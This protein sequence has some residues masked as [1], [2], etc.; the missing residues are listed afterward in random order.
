MNLKS[1]TFLVALVMATGFIVACGDQGPQNT[2]SPADQA[3]V[4]QQRMMQMYGYGSSG[5]TSTMTAM[6]YMT[7]TNTTTVNVS[8]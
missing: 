6:Q 7:I 3:W 2:L 4:K 1:L 5:T 8:H